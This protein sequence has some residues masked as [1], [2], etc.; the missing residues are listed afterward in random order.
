[1]Q[2]YDFL[3]DFKVFFWLNFA[4]YS[5]VFPSNRAMLE[6]GNLEHSILKLNKQTWEELLRE[7]CLI[8]HCPRFAIVSFCISI[9][10]SGLELVIQQGWDKFKVDLDQATTNVTIKDFYQEKNIW[11]TTYG[12]KFSNIFSASLLLLLH[13]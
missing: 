1:M 10:T 2:Y 3:D 9:P 13:L 11:A 12:D 6:N 8:Y 5:Q 4:L 7:T